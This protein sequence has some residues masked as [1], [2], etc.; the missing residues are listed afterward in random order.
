MGFCYASQFR[1]RDGYRFTVEDWIYVLPDCTGHR[2][3]RSLHEEC[4]AYAE[5]LQAG[6]ADVIYKSVQFLEGMTMGVDPLYKLGGQFV[7]G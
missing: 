4:E 2:D 7:P 1:P 6:C 3:G 5:K